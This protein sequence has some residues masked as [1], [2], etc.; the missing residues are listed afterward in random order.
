MDVEQYTAA[1]GT[2]FFISIED[3][4]NDILI[5]FCRL[6]FPDTPHR[7]ELQNS[8]IVRELHVYGQ[9]TQLEKQLESGFQHKGFGR[10]LL[11]KAEQIAETEGYEKIAVIS[12]IGVREYY[13]QNCDYYQDG[14]YV[15]K[16]L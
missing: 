4:K 6:R 14:P 9:Q 12:G 5:G 8:A 13:R 11:A 16:Y 7:P 3:F 1:G 2:E 10:Q 15:S